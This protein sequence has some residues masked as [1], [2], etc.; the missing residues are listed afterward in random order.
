MTE[1]SGKSARNLA[2]GNGDGMNKYYGK[3]MNMDFALL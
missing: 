3:P 1:T 2:D